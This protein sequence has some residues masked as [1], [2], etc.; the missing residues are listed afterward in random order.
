MEMPGFY[1]SINMEYAAKA[2]S[3]WV[4]KSYSAANSDAIKGRISHQALVTYTCNPSYS[5]GRD[6]E[7]HSLKAAWANSF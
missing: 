7:D 2:K 6:Q 1:K 3:G 5:G 4:H